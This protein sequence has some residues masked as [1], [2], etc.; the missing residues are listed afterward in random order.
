MVRFQLCGMCGSDSIE[1]RFCYWF[2]H[3]RLGMVF[4]C[5]VLH[6]TPIF[7]D[8]SYAFIFIL[9]CHNCISYDAMWP[10]M[11]SRRSCIA[12]CSLEEGFFFSPDGLHD[13]RVGARGKG[14]SNGTPFLHVCPS[15]RVSICAWDPFLRMVIKSNFWFFH[16]KEEV[17]RRNLDRGNF[18][19][20][21]YKVKNKVLIRFGIL[22]T[23]PSWF[24]L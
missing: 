16:W 3:F 2:F 23:F 12:F 22:Y 6:P 10:C 1:S 13:Q 7:L 17:K 14:I 24:T 18:R 4:L 9:T 11:V 15:L 21:I 8:S 20:S 5:M 19:N